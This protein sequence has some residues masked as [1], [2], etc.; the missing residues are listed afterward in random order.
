V[1]THSRCSYHVFAAAGSASES[2]EARP[3]AG[4]VLDVPTHSRCSYH[5]FAAAG[6]AARSCRERS[7]DAQASVHDDP[8]RIGLKALLGWRRSSGS[9][10]AGWPPRRWFLSR[11]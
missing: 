5:V 9:R 6:S 7:Q 1:P 2:G 8:L 3:A 4:G 10:A 11:G